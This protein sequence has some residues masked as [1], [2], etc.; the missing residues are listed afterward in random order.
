M[1]VEQQTPHDMGEFPSESDLVGDV[2]QEIFVRSYSGQ[3]EGLYRLQFSDEQDIY[4]ETD[5]RY[6]AEG[7]STATRRRV[8]TTEISRQWEASRGYRGGG[9]DPSDSAT[10]QDSGADPAND[11]QSRQPERRQLYTIRDGEHLV[12]CTF[13]DGP[14]HAP[15]PTR[16]FDVDKTLD[17]WEGNPQSPDLLGGT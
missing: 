9:P 8:R 4:I 14:V 10:V 3:I 15:T 12:L 11:G 6:N 1:N 13:R 2:E 16:P 17:R 7:T 5:H